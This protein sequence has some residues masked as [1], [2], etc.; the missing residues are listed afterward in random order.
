MQPE[1]S[2]APYADHS[3]AGICRDARFS[4][5]VP[6]SGLTA[7]GHFCRKSVVEGSAK[8]CVS[9]RKGDL[10]FI[11]QWHRTARRYSARFVGLSR[12]MMGV[13]DL[14]MSGR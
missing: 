12:S 14:V 10:F 8:F 5:S 1:A 9:I 2:P 3:Q 4:R 7:T 6:K 13:A 11:E